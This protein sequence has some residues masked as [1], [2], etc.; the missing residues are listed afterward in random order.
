MGYIRL[1]TTIPFL[2]NWVEGHSSYAA[3]SSTSEVLILLA[4]EQC[5]LLGLSCLVLFFHGNPYTLWF[6]TRFCLD[7]T[8]IFTILPILATRHHCCLPALQP[9]FFLVIHHKGLCHMF[10]TWHTNLP[11]LPLEGWS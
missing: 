1:P 3:N 9:F 6:R 4:K 7:F 2:D 5:P 8:F 10:D 11:S